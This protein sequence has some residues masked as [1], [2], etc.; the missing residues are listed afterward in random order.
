MTETQ[1][2]TKLADKVLARQAAMTLVLVNLGGAVVY[3]SL[4]ALNW[5]IGQERAAQLKAG[6][7]P[8]ATG[9]AIV[10]TLIEVLIC[11]CFFALDV[12]WGTVILCYR[13]WRS[14]RL[15]LVAFLFWLIAFAIDYFHH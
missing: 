8:V 13:Q 5:V 1:G 9:N 14:G 7:H 2:M 6:L 4:T 15:W 12:G 3:S 10:W 11:A